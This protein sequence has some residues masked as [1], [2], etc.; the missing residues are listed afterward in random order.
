M[1]N[2][3][4]CTTDQVEELKALIRL[5][6]I[7]STTIMIAISTY[8]TFPIV[9]A[10]KL[11]RH[12]TK[13]FEIPPS[14]IPVFSPIMITLWILLYDRAIIPLASRIKGK[15]VYGGVKLRMGIGAFLI[16]VAM[17]F[18]AIVERIRRKKAIEQGFANNPNGI[19]NMSAMW[20]ALQYCLMGLAEALYFVSLNEF[21]YSEFPKSM[22]SI[23]AS[24]SFVGSGVGNVLAGVF[25]TVVDKVSKSGG[26]ESWVAT[27]INKGHFDYLYWLLAALSLGN[28]LYYVLCSWAYGPCAETGTKTEEGESLVVVEEDKVV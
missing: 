4:L 11:D 27:N 14:T 18:I 28:V 12:L 16:S 17:A 13:K 23:A 1:N 8:N 20:V 10:S 26:K 7:L 3:N 9:Q 15:K 2:W 22:S 25:T 21:F 5:L 6:P 19:V 24:F